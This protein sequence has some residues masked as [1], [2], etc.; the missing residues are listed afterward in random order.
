MT[1][2][3]NGD[4]KPAEGR[5]KSRPVP[6]TRDTKPEPHDRNLSPGDRDEQPTPQTNESRYGAAPAAAPPPQPGSW[7]P[8]SNYAVHLTLTRPDLVAITPEQREQLVAV[9]TS[10]IL[11]FLQRQRTEHTRPE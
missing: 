2:H 8:G 9:L 4:R 11:D 10:M 1:P 6:V 7:T 3:D 5:Q